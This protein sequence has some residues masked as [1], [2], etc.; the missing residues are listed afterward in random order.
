MGQQNDRAVRETETT[1]FLRK[2]RP[3][4]QDPATEVDVHQGLVENVVHQGMT[5][6]LTNVI[7][8]HAS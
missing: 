8:S 7:D 3:I 1:V 6:A 4:D 5:A 2:R